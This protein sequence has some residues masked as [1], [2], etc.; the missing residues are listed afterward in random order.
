MPITYLI[1]YVV[2]H[3]ILSWI[4][5]DV[6]TVVIMIPFEKILEPY[7]RSREHIKSTRGRV[8]RQ[9]IQQE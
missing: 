9:S 4:I 8:K 2:V 3:V 6:K 7:D 5:A 1:S